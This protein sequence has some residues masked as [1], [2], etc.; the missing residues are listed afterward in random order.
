MQNKE[1]RKAKKETAR[2][3]EDEVATA[4]SPYFLGTKWVRGGRNVDGRGRETAKGGLDEMLCEVVLSTVL[5]I[6]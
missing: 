6:W 1:K 2:Q 3:K 4:C 5:S